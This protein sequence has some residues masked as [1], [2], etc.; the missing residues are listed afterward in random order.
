MPTNFAISIPMLLS[1]CWT[2]DFQY[3]IFYHLLVIYDSAT[4]LNP[5]RSASVLKSD[6]PTFKMRKCRFYSL[7]L[8]FIFVRIAGGHYSCSSIF[9][10]MYLI[11]FV[12][13]C[14]GCVG[15]SS[16][17]HFLSCVCLSLPLFFFVCHQVYSYS[18]V[19]CLLF[20]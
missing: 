13:L 4:L 20:H 17:L 6:H 7:K 12:Y 3:T 2:K 16:G 5:L 1:R 18:F 10:Y 19:F 15:T 14:H 9:V 11:Y 8:Y